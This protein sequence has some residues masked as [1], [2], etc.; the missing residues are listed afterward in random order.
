MFRGVDYELGYNDFQL[1]E[2]TL[3]ISGKINETNKK[4]SNKDFS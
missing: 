2:K 1:S 3:G 4:I